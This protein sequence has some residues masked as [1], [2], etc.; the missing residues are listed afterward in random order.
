MWPIESQFNPHNRVSLIQEGDEYKK[1][2]I[3][4]IDRAKTHIH[5]H[6]YIF[7]YDDVG[8]SVSEALI[9]AAAR[10][11]QIFLLVDYIGS[12]DLP[13]KVVQQ[14]LQSKIHFAWFNRFKVYN[15]FQLGRRL[16]QKVCV[17]D[18]VEA[19]VGGI[20]VI[21]PYITKKGSY[22]RLDYSVLI[23]GEVP[24]IIDQYCSRLFSEYFSGEL[25][26]LHY[27]PHNLDANDICMTRHCVND[28][29]RGKTD[30]TDSYNVAL[31]SAKKSIVIINSYFLPRKQLLKQL[32]QAE[33]RGVDVKIIL[34]RF[35][36]WK[37]WKW[38]HEYLYSYLYHSDIDI[39]EW[40]HS[41]LH[42]KVVSIDGIWCSIGSYNLNYTS[43]L[44]N[45]EMN[46]EVYNRTFVE[47]LDQI[48]DSL[49]ADDSISIDQDYL[50]NHKVFTLRYWRSFCC[51]WLIRFIAAVSM[52]IIVKGFISNFLRRRH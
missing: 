3:D 7:E 28:W 38:A 11:V 51:Y 44:A 27:T 37:G 4:L 20:N 42:A 47:Q 41:I 25:P 9:R 29:A 5:F 17:I 36:D 39:Y 24:R 22:P 30:I 21:N 13:G 16:H 1:T 40:K 19:L 2:L 35:S 50:N 33:Q 52:L 48:I 46:I 10:N 15:F 32:I 45:V 31:E 26:A 6:V 18:G 23:R 34:P 12:Q 49:I 8:K 43:Y 14:F